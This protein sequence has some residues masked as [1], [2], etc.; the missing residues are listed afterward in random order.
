MDNE[1]IAGII[2]GSH[3][4]ARQGE[5]NEE[6]KNSFDDPLRLLVTRCLF[7]PAL[8]TPAMPC[9]NVNDLSYQMEL[10]LFGEIWVELVTRASSLVV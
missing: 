4:R 9:Q 6:S 7:D 10:I 5:L 8:Q 2:D 3:E 1:Q